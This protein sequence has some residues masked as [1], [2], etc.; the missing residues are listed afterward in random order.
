MF[1]KSN[2]MCELADTGS[3]RGCFDVIKATPRPGNFR[4][5]Y[6]KM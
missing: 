6:N 2:H 3:F 5:I 4:L 1:K